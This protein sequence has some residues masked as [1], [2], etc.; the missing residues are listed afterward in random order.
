M[1]ILLA[2]LPKTWSPESVTLKY[3]RLSAS[4]SQHL[5]FKLSATYQNRP[6]TKQIKC[7]YDV[8]SLCLGFNFLKE[9]IRN[10]FF[11]KSKSWKQ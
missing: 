10:E 3:F 4:F 2:Y 9:K 7:Q 8:S 5:E 1:V 11:E 6:T